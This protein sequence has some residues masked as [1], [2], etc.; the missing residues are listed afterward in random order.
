MRKRGSHCSVYKVIN[1]RESGSLG[2]CKMRALQ[3]VFFT[4]YIKGQDDEFNYIY[5]YLFIYIQ[6]LHTHTCTN[7]EKDIQFLLNCL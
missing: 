5:V 7:N 6:Y 4:E 2:S 1:P 3:F